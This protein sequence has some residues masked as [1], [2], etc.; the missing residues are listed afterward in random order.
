MDTRPYARH[1]LLTVT[2]LA[3][4][5]CGFVNEAN[6]A[7][8]RK[9]TTSNLETLRQTVPE[10]YSIFQRLG[11]KSS[12]TVWF[13]CED[14]QLDLTTAVH[15]GTHVLTAEIQAYPLI[16]GQTATIVG[17]IRKLFRPGVLAP[18]FP[19]ASAYV[20]SY[21]MPGQASSAE[22]FG[23]LLNELNAY[24]H[25][26][27]AA[28]KLRHLAQQDYNVMHRDGLAALMAF[29]AAYV[30]RAR[31]D[32]G[33]AWAILQSASRAAHRHDA[34]G[35]GGTGNGRFLSGAPIRRGGARIPEAHLRRQYPPW[36][37]SPAGP[38]AAL[39]CKLP[40]GDGRRSAINDRFALAYRRLVGCSGRL[41]DPSGTKR[42]A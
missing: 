29:T 14:R 1:A 8:R 27:N 40:Q 32:D 11:D 39:S 28:V 31:T 13:K 10:G 19:A 25:D 9:C 41:Q 18:R 36:T 12:F 34:M 4:T 16:S 24:S 37:W 35:A 17:E 42:P 15:E 2:F 5:L 22:E 38:T 26:L 6:T 7:D 3:V 30:E 33:D 20:A 23:Y 21:L